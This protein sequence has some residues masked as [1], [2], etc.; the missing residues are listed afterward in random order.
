MQQLPSL[1]AIAAVARGAGNI[2]RKQYEQGGQVELKTARQAV[3]D[4]DLASEKYIQQ[5]LAPLL[6]ADFFG[7]EQGG[8]LRPDGYQ[9]VVD[10]LDG[11]E[12]MTGYPPV[13]GV[14]IGL[15]RDGMPVLGVVYDVL[16]DLLYTADED[17]AT[18]CNGKPCTVSGTSDPT[19]AF[20]SL[21]T[22]SNMSTRLETLRQLD[23]VAEQCRAIKIF[24]APVLSL[25]EVAHGRIDLYFRPATKLPDLVAG[26]CLVRQAGGQVT[27]YE[28]KNWTVR[29]R[30]IIAG[31]AVIL[32]A[33][34]HCFEG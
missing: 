5:G 29:S 1:D 13:V 26:V 7:E 20:V 15:L 33:F 6:Q 22:S 4:A 28:G 2:V 14:S 25:A 27:D 24:G 9:W 31:N 16:H 8:Q 10:P 19:K 11:T 17:T 32:S 23:R 34:R 21:D 3:T 12:N 30:G 18:M